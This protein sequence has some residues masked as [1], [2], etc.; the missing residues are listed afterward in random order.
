M[1]IAY[2]Q[3]S[4]YNFFTMEIKFNLEKAIQIAK[5][6]HEK[7]VDKIGESYIKHPLAVMDM[8]KG[9]DAK[10]VAVAGTP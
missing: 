4:R 5:K 2:A 1:F 10:I 3:G 7:Q 8:K 9:E 6:A